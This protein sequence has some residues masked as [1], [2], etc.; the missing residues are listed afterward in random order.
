M[1]EMTALC[2][3]ICSLLWINKLETT[4]FVQLPSRYILLILNTN[5]SEPSPSPPPQ[6]RIG[7]TWKPHSQSLRI[8]FF[9]D[10]TRGIWK[11]PGQGLNWR[12]SCQPMPQQQQRW[13]LSQVC[14][15]H[16]SSRQHWIHLDPLSEARDQTQILMD[17]SW[18]CFRC[19]TMGTLSPLGIL[20]GAITWKAAEK[21][22]PPNAPIAAE[23]RCGPLANEVMGFSL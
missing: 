13:D 8:F 18:I 16:H 15:L 21:E 1:D 12:Y 4:C 2:V 10:L 3:K 19:A 17:T 5:L 6:D 20:V 9:Q 22:K 11:F 14:N 23:S 7:K